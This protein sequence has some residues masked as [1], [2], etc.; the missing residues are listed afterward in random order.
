MP[1]HRRDSGAPGGF[2]AARGVR[3]LECGGARCGGCRAPHSRHWPRNPRCG[4]PN[5]GGPAHSGRRIPAGTCAGCLDSPEA[6]PPVRPWPWVGRRELLV[7]RR[8]SLRG[9]R[10]PEA[11]ARPVGRRHRAQ[12]AGRSCAAV[13]L[14]PRCARSDATT[15]AATRPPCGRRFADRR[16]SRSRSGT[17]RRPSTKPGQLRRRCRCQPRSAPESEWRFP[18]QGGRDPSKPRPR[19]SD[20]RRCREDRDGEKN[21]Y[22]RTGECACEA[23]PPR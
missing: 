2:Q 21:R 5:T 7:L 14:R 10:L 4:R 18:G 13:W 23:Q 11:P 15:S 19:V 3:R 9:G 8:L 1:G 22:P 20:C 17:D 6:P 16:A 12:P